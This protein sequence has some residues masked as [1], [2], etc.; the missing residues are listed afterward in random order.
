MQTPYYIRT[1]RMYCCEEDLQHFQSPS[2][3]H[4]SFVA[5]KQG[6]S[7]LKAVLSKMGV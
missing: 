2:L 5:I 7:R 3:L 4:C 6:E 1:I